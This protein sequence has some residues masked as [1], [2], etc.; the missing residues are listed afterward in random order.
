MDASIVTYACRNNWLVSKF[1]QHVISL[2]LENPNENLGV[3]RENR[4][5]NTTRLFLLL[6]HDMPSLVRM[7][8]TL[9]SMVNS[10]NEN[11]IR[12]HYN[13]ILPRND[14]FGPVA[15]ILY[16]LK[17]DIKSP[18]GRYP[19]LGT[20]KAVL[21]PFRC[22]KVPYNKIEFHGKIEPAYASGLLRAMM[23]TVEWTRVRAW[24]FMIL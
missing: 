3:R 6:G 1:K 21:E 19:S 18:S 17:F 20:Q 7:L 13:Y 24:R 14:I 15:E 23:P 5:T 8:Q 9:E 2:H 10:R 16:K 12:D 22:L 4:I 11:P